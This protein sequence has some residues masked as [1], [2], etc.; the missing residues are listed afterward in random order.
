MPRERYDG[1]DLASMEAK[2]R[3]VGLLIG[4]VMPEGAGFCLFVFSFGD[5]GWMTHVSNADRADLVKAMREWLERAEA[6]LE[7]HD[8]DR[9]T[10]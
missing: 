7:D 1:P 3:E 9:G 8:N 2:A 5:G 6:S 10:E 4:P